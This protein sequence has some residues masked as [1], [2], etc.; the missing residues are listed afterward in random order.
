MRLFPRPVQEIY[1][2]RNHNKHERRHTS[3][4]DR[5]DLVPLQLV[6]DRRYDSDG[7]LLSTL[8]AVIIGLARSDRRS[9][10]LSIAARVRIPIDDLLPIRGVGALALAV[11]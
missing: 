1:P 6:V 3:R 4:P 10:S 5:E 11:E 8:Y 2:Q 9:S 7:V